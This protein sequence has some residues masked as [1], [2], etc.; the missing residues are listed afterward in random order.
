MERFFG[1]GK[2]PITLKHAWGIGLGEKWL[3]E[4][5]NLRSVAE[6]CCPATRIAQAH[7]PSML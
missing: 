4:Q 6:A 5:E 3:P 1:F 7:S 2:N